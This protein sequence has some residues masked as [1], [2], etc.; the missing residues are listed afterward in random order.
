MILTEVS[1]TLPTRVFCEERV[2]CSGTGTDVFWSFFGLVTPIPNSEN[3]FT[4]VFIIYLHLFLGVVVHV[5]VPGKKKFP[6][7][8]FA[9][10]VFEN[11][12]LLTMGFQR[13]LM[14]KM[15]LNYLH[16]K[17]VYGVKIMILINLI[18][19]ALQLIQLV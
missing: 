11:T 19:K 15:M 6:S 16:G 13:F 10:S 5:G 17:V 18:D 12:Q 9:I 7:N 3:R 2:N 4:E 8:S 14:S 1:G